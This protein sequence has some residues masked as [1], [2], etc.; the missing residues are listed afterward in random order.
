MSTL[1]M[2]FLLPSVTGKNLVVHLLSSAHFH[3][4]SQI[5]LMKTSLCP[6]ETLNALRSMPSLAVGRT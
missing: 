5:A 3:D 2:V 4:S 1:L 6:N